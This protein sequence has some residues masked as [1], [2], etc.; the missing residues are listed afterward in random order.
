MKQYIKKTIALVLLLM[1]GTSTWGA[2]DGT[3]RTAPSETQ[4]IE[5]HTYTII[6]TE[7][8]WAWLCND[9]QNGERYIKL[10]ADLDMGSHVLS[11]I[12]GGTSRSV[13]GVIDGNNKTISNLHVVKNNSWETGGIVGYMY[14][15]TLKNLHVVNGLVES[16]QSG[17]Y[18]IGGLVGGFGSN[19][20]IDH[21]SFIGTVD[22][23][24]KDYVGGIVGRPTN[25]G[26][27][28]TNCYFD[29][30]VI[31]N[32]YVGAIIGQIG[33]ST[34]ESGNTYSDTSSININGV[35]I[36]GNGTDIKIGK[37]ASDFITYALTKVSTTNGS[38]T[39][40]VGAGNAT[41]ATAGAPIT[42][43][44]I[45]ATGYVVN[46]VS[47]V[48]A[49]SNSVKVT[50]SAANAYTFTMPA[51]NVT[52][53]VTFGEPGN[54]LVKTIANSDGTITSNKETANKNEVVTLTVTPNDGKIITASNIIVTKTGTADM[55]QSR[56]LDDSPLGGGDITVTAVSVDARGSGTYQFTMPNTNVEISATFT[57][58]NNLSAATIGVSGT[59]TYDGTPKIPSAS[60]TLSGTPLTSNDYTL[61]YYL[62]N[63]TTP[64][65]GT[66]ATTAPTNAGSYKVKAQG[67]NTYTGTTKTGASF[68]INKAEL[69]IIAKPKVINYGDAPANDGV[70]YSGFVNSENN[71]VL[72][73]T[74]V[75]SYN[76]NQYDNVGTYTITP[77][78]LTSGNYTISFVTGSL[79]VNPKVVTSPTITLGTTSYTY[80][81]T[82][83]K[84]TVTAVKDGERTI[85]S[86]EYTVSYE[87]NIN[88]GTATVKITDKDGGNYTV[89]GS[90][91]FSIA[92]ADG[93]MVP[94]TGKSDLVYTGSPM[95]LITAGTSTTGTV[96]YSLDGSTY[97][98]TIPQGE[99]A[100]EYTIYY[101]VVANP[102]YNDVAAQSFKVTIAPKTVT[103]PTITLSETSYIYDNKAK[104]PTV[105][106]KDGDTLIPAS[107]YAV[108]YEDNVK[109]GKATVKITD[110]DG[111]NYIVNG[112]AT[113]SI[114]QDMQT[115]EV[116]T[117]ED[118]TVKTDIAATITD[119]GNKEVTITDAVIP[120]SEAGSTEAAIP[121]TVEIGGNTYT[122]TEI[123]DNAF[124]GKTEITDI[125]LPD[126]EEPITLG[127]DALKISDTEIARVHTP[128][129]LLDDYALDKGLEQNLEAEKLMA[130]VTP[131]NQYWT[132]SC[133]I[134]V[135]V[136]EGVKVYKCILNEEGTAVVIIQ[137][138]DAD[139]GGI[140]KANNGV[141]I[142]CTAGNAYDII[143]SKNASITTISDRD[144]KS[145]GR[146]NLLE[147]VIESKNYAAG[148]YYV[149][150]NNEF[151]AILDNASKVPACKAVLHKP[152]G[153]SAS[154]SMGI[155][156]DGTTGISR[157][158]L[159]DDG[160]EWYNVQ[161]Q[162]ISNP[163]KSGLYIKNGKK[164]IVK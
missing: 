126:T 95:D 148:D 106:V 61:L 56:S 137:I 5:G 116:E 66:D 82:E 1:A 145:Y 47:V 63:G 153:V 2:W 160:A 138:S 154:R 4:T 69:S 143:A 110:K 164:V 150:K 10:N 30:T 73:G 114:T 45:P 112:S 87:D 104:E 34:I 127:E 6:N 70:E 161:G 120:A 42:I 48:D 39:V 23:G 60:V 46:S 131:P 158:S 43:N 50:K 77:S 71:S 141:L 162:R 49:S 108:S 64:A 111:G 33:S 83:K 78:G 89:S 26:W 152:A 59:Y 44:T 65:V 88:V 81:G 128:L 9:W 101:K 133:G 25:T 35:A 15:C 21:C 37:K 75:Y 79:T 11:D 52:I 27:V 125:Y 121:P 139:L 62:E 124:A 80:D 146:D 67:K 54:Y 51:S 132:F 142:S 55:A 140:I 118:K 58:N 3:T 22:A 7:A 76:Y 40:K 91:T 149:L 74:L 68:T 86:E 100:K 72:G 20:T 123:A 147:P 8:E 16:T 117:E 38:F 98:T 18:G 14:N 32:N 41:K 19:S 102:G 115:V 109:I 130:T 93:S 13:S 136:P 105:T 155:N 12:I 159:E 129:A 156:E 53:T 134:D 99:E 119:E 107:E 157:I 31:G 36:Y 84:P 151:H 103:E 29:G 24:D 90:A 96:Q 28:I 85:P 57:K 163:T 94:P 17:N 135:K 92:A 144:E 97:D 113:F 122:V